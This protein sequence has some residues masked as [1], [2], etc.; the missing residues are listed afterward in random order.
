MAEK[1]IICMTGLSRT[2]SFIATDNNLNFELAFKMATALH[3]LKDLSAV[4]EYWLFVK[5]GY[6]RIYF[7]LWSQ[8]KRPAIEM[9]SR[10]YY[11]AK[12]DDIFAKF[13]LGGQIFT[14]PVVEVSDKKFR[15]SGS[16]TKNAFQEFQEAARCLKQGSE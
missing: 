12:E 16:S 15:F 10:C 8:N 9:L 7:N 2:A 3:S 4:A 6:A 1:A 13:T 5:H 14:L 11:D